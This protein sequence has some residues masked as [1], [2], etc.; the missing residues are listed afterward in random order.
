MVDG[1]I[2]KNVLKKKFGS[3]TLKNKKKESIDIK[4]QRY[5]GDVT[6]FFFFYKLFVLLML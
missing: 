3:R 2:D 1:R 4:K 6:L 5:N